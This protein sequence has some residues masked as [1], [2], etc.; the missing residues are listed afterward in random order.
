MV[1]AKIVFCR[2]VNNNRMQEIDGKGDQ[3]HTN[4]AVYVSPATKYIQFKEHYS[5]YL[6]K[7]YLNT[8]QS[9]NKKGQQ[10]HITDS[11][12][13]QLD[14]LLKYHCYRPGQDAHAE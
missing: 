3:A 8:H 2:E 10:A 5:K 1:A 9:N 7:W 6:S 13:L 4:T 11:L 14:Q 12:T